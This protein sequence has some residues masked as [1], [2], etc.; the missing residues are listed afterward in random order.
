MESC[1][2]NEQSKYADKV[3]LFLPVRAFMA[4]NNNPDWYFVIQ[5]QDPLEPKQESNFSCFSLE[6][7]SSSDPTQ[8][9]SFARFSV[10]LF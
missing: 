6:F 3:T 10:Y 5:P 2:L 4:K 7:L 1:G 8:G 9:F